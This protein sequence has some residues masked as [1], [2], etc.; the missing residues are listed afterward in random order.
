MRANSAIISANVASECARAGAGDAVKRPPAPD[1]R[2]ARVLFY[3]NSCIV[4]GAGG[5]AH[6]AAAGDGAELGEELA[7]LGVVDGVLEV[8]DV[9]VGAGHLLEPLAA[10]GVELRLELSLTL[11]LL[12]C[13]ADDPRLVLNL[14]VAVELLDRLGGCLGS[15]KQT[16]PKPLDLPSPS[17]M[18]TT[19]VS[20]PMAPNTSLSLSS[21]TDS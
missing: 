12:L 20:L 17:F 13:A 1:A 11:G 3:L 5:V 2:I 16:K 10:L 7:E 4:P 9:E 18:M 14:V 21:S 19:E 15:S 8:L 6:D